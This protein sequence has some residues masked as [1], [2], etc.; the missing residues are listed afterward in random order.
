MPNTNEYTELDNQRLD[1]LHTG[2]LFD[3]P[4]IFS[5]E[6]IIWQVYKQNAILLGGL[7]AVLLQ[8]S[9]PSVA[10][11]VLEHSQFKL[12]TIKR[13]KN[14]VISMYDIIFGTPEA[15]KRRTKKMFQIHNRV[16]GFV[17]EG[18]MSKWDNRNY[19]ANEP[20]LLHWVAVTTAD[21]VLT[22]FEEFC[23]P[24]TKSELDRFTPNYNIVA[25]LLG[26][27]EQHRCTC[28]QDLR[29][30]YYQQ[31]KSGNVYVGDNAKDIYRELK[32]LG[33]SWSASSLLASK[34]MPAE[35]RDAY[36][37]TWNDSDQQKFER[38]KRRVKALN[39]TLPY[40]RAYYK[41]RRLSNLRV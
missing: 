23:R 9:N 15:A 12:Q 18:S 4:T 36:G 17:N 40:S 38:V 24:L 19:R 21:S 25:D 31:Y 32:S 3:T 29:G 20:E 16:F 1:D 11:G 13:L 22:A 33:L 7:R 34:H 35:V 28:I 37:L 10:A 27:G 41:A 8:V 2:L 30:Y 39:E 5:D 26:V 14:T 6:D